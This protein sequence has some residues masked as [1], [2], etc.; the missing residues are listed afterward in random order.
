M[1]SSGKI[2]KIFLEECTCVDCSQALGVLGRGWGKT[3]LLTLCVYEMLNLFTGACTSYL[4]EKSKKKLLV[5]TINGT[6]SE[7]AIY[8]ILLLCEFN[9]SHAGLLMGTRQEVSL[10]QRT[11]HDTCPHGPPG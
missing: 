3:P 2:S 4:V 9:I 7:G 10:F 8:E 11:R 1:C 6:L 5:L